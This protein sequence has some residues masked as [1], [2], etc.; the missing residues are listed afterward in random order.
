MSSEKRKITVDPKEALF[1]GVKIVGPLMA[2]NGFTFHFRDEGSGSGGKFAWGE[3]VRKDRRLELHF[4]HSL[5][6]VRYHVRKASVSHEAYMRELGVWAQCR[7]PGFSDNPMDAFHDLAHDLQFAGDFLSGRGESVGRAFAM[8]KI[9]ASSRK[10]EHMADWPRSVR[11]MLI[12]GLWYSPR[13]KD[14]H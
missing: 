1:E 2:S 6:L 8:E 3:F 13:V 4:R 7:Y 10:A 11:P 9:D 12:R 5:G 14:C